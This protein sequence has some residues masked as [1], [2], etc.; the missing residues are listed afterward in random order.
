M[1][2]FAKIKPLRKFPNLQLF[3]LHSQNICLRVRKLIII[4]I[5]VGY[6]LLLVFCAEIWYISQSA[7]TAAVFFDHSGNIVPLNILAS[8]R[9]EPTIAACAPSTAMSDT[10]NHHIT[11]LCTGVLELCTLMILLS[12]CTND[13]C[14]L[15]HN[16]DIIHINIWLL[17]GLN[18]LMQHAC[19]AFQGLK[20]L[21]ITLPKH[22]QKRMLK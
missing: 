3:L 7:A 20:P 9:V 12:V 13:T 5:F 15:D 18:P 4:I 11:D 2:S 21:T 6:L 19:L 22:P 10:L 17:W 16:G 14:L 8:V 1:R